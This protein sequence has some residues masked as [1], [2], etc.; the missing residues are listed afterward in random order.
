MF[1]AKNIASQMWELENNSEIEILYYCISAASAID[2]IEP[3]TR[4]QTYNGTRSYNNWGKIFVNFH[5]KR[6]ALIVSMIYHESFIYYNYFQKRHANHGQTLNRLQLS[7]AFMT[8]T[9]VQW[10][11][12][13]IIT[14]AAIQ[15]MIPKAPGVFIVLMMVDPLTSPVVA[16]TIVVRSLYTIR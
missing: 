11:H 2:C 1:C 5:S 13:I 12:R 10:N 15:T 8:L 9:L 7:M 6:H 14:T 16:L 4:G 3:G